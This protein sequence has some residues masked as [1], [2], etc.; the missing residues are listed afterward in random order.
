M[1]TLSSNTRTTALE[2]S[3]SATRMLRLGAQ[4][5]MTVTENEILDDLEFLMEDGAR[6]HPTMEPLV[7]A[8]RKD[9]ADPDAFLEIL[10]DRGLNGF[11]VT[12]SRRSPG[13]SSNPP[14]QRSLGVVRAL[15][16]H[17]RHHR[18]R[19]GPR[20][21]RCDHG[22]PARRGFRP[23]TGQAQ[24]RPNRSCLTRT[25]IVRRNRLGRERSAR[26]HPLRSRDP[27][28][29]TGS[30]SSCPAPH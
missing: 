2:A 23:R 7:T 11:V 16:L 19:R 10:S 4:A 17:D 3:V 29:R 30:E 18:L 6:L 8:L 24:D 5:D 12:L 25:E 26:L 22:G 28:A 9:D 14:G 27:G 15:G 1:K 20:G 13:I 21:D